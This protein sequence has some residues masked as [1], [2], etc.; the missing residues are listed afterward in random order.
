MSYSKK[1]MLALLRDLM[2]HDRRHQQRLTEVR[3]V[4]KTAAPT[5]PRALRDA[6][7][8]TTSSFDLATDA[9]D[10]IVRRGSITE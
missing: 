2:E 10:A 8:S 4:A 9:R 5:P 6:G 3:S 1:G 7:W